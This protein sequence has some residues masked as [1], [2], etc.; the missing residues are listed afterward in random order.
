V[1][2]EHT[3]DR[4]RERLVC[5]DGRFRN[6]DRGIELTSR[7]VHH[8]VGLIDQAGLH[9]LTAESRSDLGTSRMSEAFDRLLHGLLAGIDDPVGVC[10]SGRPPFIRVQHGP[11][12]HDERYVS[13]QRAAD[14]VLERRRFRTRMGSIV[15]DDVDTAVLLEWAGPLVHERVAREGGRAGFVATHD[16]MARKLQV[17]DRCRRG[18]TIRLDHEYAHCHPS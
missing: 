8:H 1:G 7:A 17:D 13:P 12:G 6:S 10:D 5:V 14:P 2:T 11:T 4:D 16:L 15:E 3:G 18:I 9:A